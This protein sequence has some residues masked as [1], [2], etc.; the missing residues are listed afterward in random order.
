MRKAKLLCEDPSCLQLLEAKKHAR[1]KQVAAV[2]AAS[3]AELE[4]A[5]V[6]IKAAWRGKSGPIPRP[7]RFQ[8][9]ND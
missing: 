4:H 9:L 5:A 3:A 2:Y 7:R 1:D 6:L 8:S